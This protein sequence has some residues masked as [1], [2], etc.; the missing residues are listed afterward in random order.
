MRFFGLER[1]EESAASASAA[2]KAAIAEAATT[3]PHAL[4]ARN[5]P[6]PTLPARMAQTRPAAA[7]QEPVVATEE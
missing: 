5:M 1:P 2:A 7:R 4:A 3:A 6:R